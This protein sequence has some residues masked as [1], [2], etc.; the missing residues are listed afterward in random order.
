MLF[1]LGVQQLEGVTELGVQRVRTVPGNFETAAARRSVFRERRD[2]DVSAGSDGTLDLLHV[3]ATICLGGEK[4][5]DR[6][7]V[8]D[9]DRSLRQICG[10]DVGVEPPDFVRPWTEPGFRLLQSR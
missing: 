6:S 3:L 10:Q 1:G 8:P 4:V 9:V 7:I 2:Q 5:K